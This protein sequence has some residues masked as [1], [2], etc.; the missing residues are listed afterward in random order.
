MHKLQ[1]SPKQV[2]PFLLVL[3]AFCVRIANNDF[4]LLC[5]S[6]LLTGK[7]TTKPLVEEASVEY[8]ARYILQIS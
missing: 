2:R 6:L 7:G 5:R 4:V 8:I 3:V 1:H